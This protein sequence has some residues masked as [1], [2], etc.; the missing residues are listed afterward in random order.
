MVCV[1]VGKI[2]DGEKVLSRTV[3]SN[4]PVYLKQRGMQAS[5][6][7]VTS[8]SRTHVTRGLT[9]FTGLG[10]HGNGH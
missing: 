4:I 9:M 3:T 1:K 6:L 7:V 2:L 5:D 10:V 8:I